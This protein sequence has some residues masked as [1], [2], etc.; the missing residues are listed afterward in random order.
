MSAEFWRGWAAC[1]L[2]AFVGLCALV[3]ALSAVVLLIQA[4]ARLRELK[5]GRQ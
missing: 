3:V 2:V 4:R 5:G 1:V